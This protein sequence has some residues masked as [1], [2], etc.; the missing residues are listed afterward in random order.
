MSAAAAAAAVVTRP[1]H[2]SARRSTSSSS[3]YNDD[4]NQDS[5]YNTQINPFLQTAQTPEGDYYYELYQNTVLKQLR[6]YEISLGELH[7]L[8]ATRHQVKNWSQLQPRTTSSRKSIWCR[9][10]ETCIKSF[11]SEKRKKDKEEIMELNFFC[12]L[13]VN[14]DWMKRNNRFLRQ[15]KEYGSI[16]S[17]ASHW[18]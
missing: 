6:S 4:F 3:Y 1:S 15:I 7:N 17:I 16:H 11:G 9:E 12:N 13:V 5:S 18:K 14:L 10:F 2:S 8:P